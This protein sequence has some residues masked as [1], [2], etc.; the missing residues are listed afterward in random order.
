M[1]KYRKMNEGSCI[2]VTNLDF[3][4]LFNIIK[5]LLKFHEA[6]CK[7]SNFVYKN[8]YYFKKI[9]HFFM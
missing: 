8:I 2:I 5:C 9:M 3:V 1:N 7:L 4:C 6:F